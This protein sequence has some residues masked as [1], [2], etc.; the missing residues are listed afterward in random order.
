[1]QSIFAFILFFMTILPGITDESVT[2]GAAAQITSEEK[3]AA[4]NVHNQARQEVGAPPLE[5]SDELATYAQEW[6]E[7]LAQE[8]DC[9]IAHRSWLGKDEKDYGEN[10]FWGIG[11]EYSAGYASEA[12]YDEIN[13]YTYQN[14]STENLNGTGHYSQMVWKDT[15]RIGIGK[16]KCA[17]GAT[18]IVASYDPPGN[19]IGQK[20]Y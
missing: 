6:A 18:I 14:V 7:Y 9:K 17:S 1:M 15:Q 5:W 10:I 4:L 13:K 12:W 3:E 19:V 16:A 20:P 11:R 8:N 2:S